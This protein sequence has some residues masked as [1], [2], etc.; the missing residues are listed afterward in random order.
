[1]AAPGA[2]PIR[3]HNDY[4]LGYNGF[5][6]LLQSF[7]APQIFSWTIGHFSGFQ[8]ANLQPFILLNLAQASSSHL[9]PAREHLLSD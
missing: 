9:T 1:M 5:Y 3:C 6:S 2:C 7:L 8:F 4:Y